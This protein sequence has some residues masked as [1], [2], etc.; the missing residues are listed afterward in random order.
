MIPANDIA[1][2][3]LGGAGED[4]GTTFGLPLPESRR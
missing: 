3:G 4:E 2:R 1:Q